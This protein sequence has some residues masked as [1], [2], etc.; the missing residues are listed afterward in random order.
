MTKINRISK[1]LVSIETFND[2]QMTVI[3]GI[4]AFYDNAVKND[5]E[6][7]IDADTRKRYAKR[8]YRR[9]EILTATRATT[10]KTCNPYYISKNVFLHDVDAHLFLL[11]RAKSAT[12]KSAKSAKRALAVKSLD[13]IALLTSS[14]AVNETSL[15][16]A[17][18][19]A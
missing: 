13:A 6:N 12:A 4:I 19:T 14:E 8:T 18:V 5:A 11:N 2:K 10:D 17:L 16:T 7:S 9:V 3:N 15:V 1:A